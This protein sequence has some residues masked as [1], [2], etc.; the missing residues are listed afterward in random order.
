MKILFKIFFCLKWF[1][2]FVTKFIEWLL[3]RL[4]SLPF[5]YD[6]S[7]I[8]LSMDEKRDRVGGREGERERESEIE[9]EIKSKGTTTLTVTTFRITTLGT[10]TLRMTIKMEA[11]STRTL[12]IPIRNA[13]RRIQLKCDTQHNYEIETFSIMTLDADRRYAECHSH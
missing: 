4:P 6:F 3:L 12:S 5:L 2:S 9:R 10:T 13:T 11:L 1:S 8:F 7:K